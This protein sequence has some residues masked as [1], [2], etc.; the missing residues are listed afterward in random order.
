MSGKENPCC[1]DNFQENS[2]ILVLMI[3]KSVHWT[4]N[5]QKFKESHTMQ[6]LHFTMNYMYMYYGRTRL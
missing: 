5:K 4:Y 6:D 1:S 3:D 2:L